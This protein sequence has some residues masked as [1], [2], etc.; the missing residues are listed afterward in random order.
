MNGT[1]AGWNS[2][3]SG[4]NSPGDPPAAMPHHHAH[5]PA[6]IPGFLGYQNQPT[7]G[8]W[9]TP[10]TPPAT[11]PPRSRGRLIIACALVAGV[12]IVSTTL[13]LT[14]PHPPSSS[15]STTGSQTP[16][17]TTSAASPVYQVLPYQALPYAVDMQRLIGTPMTLFGDIGVAPAPDANAV[18]ANCKF[19]A[20]SV[21]QSTWKPA[22][23]IATQHYLEGAADNYTAQ[24]NAALAVFDT[25]PAAA[26][27]LSLVTGSVRGCTTF[28]AP[29][30]NPRL[31][32]TTWT[33]TD[34]DA[35]SDHVTWT[36]AQ[37]D[38]QSCRRSYRVTANIAA[39]ALVRGVDVN[40]AAATTL[41]EYMLTNATKQ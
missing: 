30:W 26:T 29:D 32:P 20:M 14:R 22:R 36:T 12:G 37:G 21:S 1:N 13:V 25:T 4:A 41:T 38:G 15:A 23:A 27:S 8:Q 28:T 31:P 16:S 6:P 2:Q 9:A 24:A 3:R 19:A 11:Q 33:V 18:P 17:T 39:S 7:G 35:G 40:S 10:S 34:V 5:T